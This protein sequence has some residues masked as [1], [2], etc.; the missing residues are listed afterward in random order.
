[1]VLEKIRENPWDNEEM[2][3]VSP[4]GT[5]PSLEG[6]MLKLKIPVLWPPD[7]DI[8]IFGKDPD[9]GKD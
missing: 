2:Q 6:L 9:A 7:V 5:Q 1:M 8:Q 3:P 4:K